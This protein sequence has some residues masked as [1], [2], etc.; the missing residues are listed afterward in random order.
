MII[1]ASTTHPRIT[2]RSASIIPSFVKCEVDN[3]RIRSVFRELKSLK[4][5]KHVNSTALMMRTL[6]ELCLS[7]YIDNTNKTAELRAGFDKKGNHADDWYP[8]LRQQL[9]FMD[10]YYV[11]ELGIKPLE[12]KALR[13]F[14]QKSNPLSH[15]ILDGYVHNKHEI[16]TEPELR[17]IWEA[18]EAL[19]SVLLSKG[20]CA[21]E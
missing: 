21:G 17:S 9:T 2:R 15:E 3:F 7:N 16:P 11:N 19:I 5:D 14:S 12:L 8:T 18:I 10:K 6:L 13:K 1:K 20:S 4:V